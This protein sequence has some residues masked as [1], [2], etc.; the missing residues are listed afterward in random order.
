M[1]SSAQGLDNNIYFGQ[2]EQILKPFDGMTGASFNYYSYANGNL[3]VEMVKDETTA[4][5]M[6]SRKE[7]QDTPSFALA[8]QRSSSSGS[9]F[10]R[11]RWSPAS[12]NP[13]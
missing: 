13:G 2:V 9:I 5:R 4:R 7:G 12:E 11:S 1:L 8:E 3:P 10:L 6:C